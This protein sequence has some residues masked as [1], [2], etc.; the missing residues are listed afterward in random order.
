[1]SRVVSTISSQCSSRSDPPSCSN[2]SKGSRRGQSRRTSRRSTRLRAGS[3]CSTS[4][5]AST[6]RWRRRQGAEQLHCV[7]GT[8]DSAS[9]LP[10]TLP[11]LL[12]PIAALTCAR[13]PRTSSTR[14]TSCARLAR[15]NGSLPKTC[16]PQA[17]TLRSSQKT[18]TRCCT[19]IRRTALATFPASTRVPLRQSR[20]SGERRATPGPRPILRP[21]SKHPARGH[22]RQSTRPGRCCTAMSATLTPSQFRDLLPTR[23]R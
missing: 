1:M 10:P 15:T 9:V 22:R 20:G 12:T 18:L 5:L 7:S 8:R 11:S 14:R 23:R 3:T 19:R 21:R 13:A 6:K 2:S 4:H 17:T 16:V